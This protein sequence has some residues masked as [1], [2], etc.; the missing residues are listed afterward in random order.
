LANTGAA[1][2]A[3]PRADCEDDEDCVKV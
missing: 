3:C 1:A 2:V